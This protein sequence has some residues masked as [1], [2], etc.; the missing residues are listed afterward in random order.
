MSFLEN[1]LQ[2]ITPMWPLIAF[3]FFILQSALLESTFYFTS[4]FQEAQGR[5]MTVLFDQVLLSPWAARSPE[6]W[7]T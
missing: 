2:S 5:V 3:K 4:C 6:L 1:T 7:L